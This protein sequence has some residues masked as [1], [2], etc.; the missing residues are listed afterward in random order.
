MSSLNI[1]LGKLKHAVAKEKR[2]PYIK[3]RI[4]EPLVHSEV[5]FCYWLGLV[6]LASIYMA[7]LGYFLFKWE[8]GIFLLFVDILLS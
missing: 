5:L 2:N 7:R 3:V 1:S 6:W 4:S 8:K